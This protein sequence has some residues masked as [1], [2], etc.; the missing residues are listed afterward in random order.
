MN[1]ISGINGTC[2]ELSGRFT[3]PADKPAARDKY[4]WCPVGCQPVKGKTSTPPTASLLVSLW[5]PPGAADTSTFDKV[6]T[7]VLTRAAEVKAD[8]RMV[9]TRFQGDECSQ[10]Q[11]DCVWWCLFAYQR[12]THPRCQVETA[13]RRHVGFSEALKKQVFK[14]TIV[15]FWVHPVVFDESKNCPNRPLI[16]LILLNMEVMTREGITRQIKTGFQDKRLYS[17]NAE[18]GLFFSTRRGF[19]THK[20]QLISPWSFKSFVVLQKRTLPNNRYKKY[21]KKIA[22]NTIKMFSNQQNM[23][24]IHRKFRLMTVLIII[25]LLQSRLQRLTQYPC[26]LTSL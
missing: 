13:Y 19:T 8:C 3:G 22:E 4:A 2:K 24:K 17:Q 6:I 7:S 26:L 10:N 18:L 14:H 20:Y 25:S 1:W 5:F 9:Q 21:D 15:Y 23:L 12:W 11:A 16:Y